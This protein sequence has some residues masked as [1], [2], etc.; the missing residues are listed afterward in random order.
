[1]SKAKKVSATALPNQTDLFGS[2]TLEQGSLDVNDALCIQCSKALKAAEKLNMS[3]HQVAGAMNDLIFGDEVLQDVPLITA[4]RIYDWNS[5]AKK[6]RRWPA[7]YLPVYC[8][9]C[10]YFDPLKFL[11]SIVFCEVLV[12][13]E[14]RFIAKA[15][16]LQ[17]LEAA[18]KEAKQ[19]GIEV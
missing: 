14:V 10:K 4:T 2:S 8:F 18:K 15:R 6:E 3:V 9:V 7:Q 13:E 19:L 17:K 1:M 11:G 12:G 5:R 16:A